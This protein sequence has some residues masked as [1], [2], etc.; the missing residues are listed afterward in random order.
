MNYNAD[1]IRARDLS[2]AAIHEAG[3]VIVA[4][5]LGLVAD[6]WLIPA[7]DGGI[8]NQH[9]VGKT[10][11]MRGNGERVQ[12]WAGSIAEMLL[13]DG[14]DSD[15]A[16]WLIQEAAE[17]GEVSATDLALAGGADWGAEDIERCIALVMEHAASI[18]AEADR[19]ISELSP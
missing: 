18:R 6:A 14:T 19:L 17:A 8:D 16:Y 5:A 15:T 10:R 13:L 7:P 3:H 2:R 12:A 11:V 9:W 1:E 4:R